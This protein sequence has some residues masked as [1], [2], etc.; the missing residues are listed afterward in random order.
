M[1]RTAGFAIMSEVG[2]VFRLVGPTNS[3]GGVTV[4]RYLFFLVAWLVILPAI[5]DDQPQPPKQET[6][7]QEKDEAEIRK[8]GE[9]YVKAF[10]AGDAE[11]LAGFWSP[12]AVYTNRLT[13]EQVL[14]REAI[15]EQ[16]KLLF[17]AAEEIKLNV[18]VDSIQFVS[19]NVAVEN[20]MANFVSGESE[21]EQVRY[22]AVYT[23]RDGM[24]LLD[25]VTDDPT[26]P[27]PPNY[28]HLK[29]LGWMIGTWVDEDKNARIET[30]CNWTKNKTFITRS[31]SVSIEGQIDLSGMQV[32]GWDAAKK[33]V[34]SWTFDSDGGFAEGVW[35]KKDDRWYIQKTGVLPD[36]RKSS[37]VNI[38]TKIDHNTFTLRSVARAVGGEI[39]P[40]I[41]EVKVVRV[42]D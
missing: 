24:W 13:G 32:V 10:N 35:S 26:P 8:T 16:F 38:V 14:G 33:Q 21:P 25:R 1:F 15:A 4:K 5:A 12:E 37:A 41:D 42:S 31:F 7:D 17:E 28:E 18:S 39:L 2:I 27:A 30:E 19:P 23:R 9:A 40:D 36:G 22:S 34:R 3:K 29:E 20:G 6:P 11:K